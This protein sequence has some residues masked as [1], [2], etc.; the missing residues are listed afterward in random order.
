[1]AADPAGEGAVVTATGAVEEVEDP[2]DLALI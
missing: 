2:A 1:L